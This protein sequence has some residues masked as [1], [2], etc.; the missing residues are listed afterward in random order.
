MRP[1]LGLV[2]IALLAAPAKADD[3]EQVQIWLDRMARAVE[4]LN[5]RGTLVHVRDGQI[6]TLRIIHRADEEGVRERIFS[7]DGEQREILRNGSKVRC[8]L[9][10]DAGSIV[11]SELT[12]RMLPL[13][14]ARRF[15]HSQQ[16][17]RFQ[18][19]STERVADHDTQVVE[20]LP[21]DGFRYGHRFWLE[22]QTGMLMRAVLMDQYGEVLQQLSFADVELGVPISDA[23]LAPTMVTSRSLSATLDA[24]ALG[25]DIR[26]EQQRPSMPR[27]SWFPRRLPAG[28]RL[29]AVEQGVDDKGAPLHHLLYSDGLASFSVYL[30]ERDGAEQGDSRIE[31]FGPVHVYT[32]PADDH[33]ITVV[34]E[35]PLQTVKLV[36][37]DV[38]RELARARADTEQ[39]AR[40]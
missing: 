33:T 26:S 15:N 28:F 35:V 18:L 20:I 30:E 19:G 8:L 36:G 39:A 12:S 32:G 23:E 7:L 11:E 21:N 5:Y 22:T 37:Q 40:Q 2:L 29:V 9:P 4:T 25:D 34:G 6:D 17:Y 14:P 1:L 10:D 27:Q 3:A 13:L 38:R 24:Q 31:A 16:G